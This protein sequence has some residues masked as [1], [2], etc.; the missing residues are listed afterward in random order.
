MSTLLL[1][2][3]SEAT[4]L[5]LRR[6]RVSPLRSN[7]SKVTLSQQYST[8]LNLAAIMSAHASPL[9]NGRTA[10]ADSPLGAHPDNGENGQLSSAEDGDLFGDD[11]ADSADDGHER[12]RKLDD[13][14]LDSADEEDRQDRF[15]DTAEGDERDGTPP[16]QKTERLLTSTIS[17]IKPPEADEV[18]LGRQ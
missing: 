17:R 2:Y 13:S 4:I 5:L 1:P 14:E 11:D 8:V 15:A 9:T 7:S 10:D 12:Q 3:T 6:G 16:R 18:I